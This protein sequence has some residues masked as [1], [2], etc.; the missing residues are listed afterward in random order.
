MIADIMATEPTEKHGKKITKIR[1]FSVSF[2]GF[3]GYWR[4][5]GTRLHGFS[6]DRKSAPDLTLPPRLAGPDG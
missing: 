5:T 2:R 4:N 3:R 1:Y 6:R